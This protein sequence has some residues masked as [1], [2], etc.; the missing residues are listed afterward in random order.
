M[1]ELCLQQLHQQGGVRVKAASAAGMVPIPTHPQF[2]GDQPGT[3]YR[4]FAQ[5]AESWVHLAFRRLEEVFT[6]ASFVCC[7]FWLKESQLISTEKA[8]NKRSTTVNWLIVNC[9]RWSENWTGWK[10]G[11]QFWKD[12][13][14]C[15]FH[16]FNMSQI[17]NSYNSRSHTFSSTASFIACIFL[18]IQKVAESK[19]GTQVQAYCSSPPVLGTLKVSGKIYLYEMYLNVQTIVFLS[20]H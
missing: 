15:S 18:C 3:G 9:W 1:R 12:F 20:R 5:E 13:S 7:T 8:C 17:G 14:G 16:V 6:Q 11:F 2:Q 19:N 10:L 4:Y